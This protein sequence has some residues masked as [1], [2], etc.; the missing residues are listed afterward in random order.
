[1]SLFTGTKIDPHTPFPMKESKEISTKRSLESSLPWNSNKEEAE[2]ET[3]YLNHIPKR[4]YADGD[5]NIFEEFFAL[6]Q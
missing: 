1:M 3:D 2:E 6:V 5:V 4:P